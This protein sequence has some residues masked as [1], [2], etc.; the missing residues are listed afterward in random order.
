MFGFCEGEG[1]GEACYACSDDDDVHLSRWADM[2]PVLLFDM[3]F[4]AE[5]RDVGRLRA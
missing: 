5:Y 4:G 1:Q 3:G 2:Y